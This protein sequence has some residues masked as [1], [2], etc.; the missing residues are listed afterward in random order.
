MQPKSSKSTGLTFTGNETSEN[1]DG[2]TLSGSMS[3]AA[4][5]PVRTFPTPDEGQDL[6]E[7][8]QDCFSRPFAWFANYDPDA[9]CWK[10]WQRCLLGDWIEFSGRWP[11]SG[12][13]RN[14]I[15]YRLPVLVPRISGTGCS[16]WPTPNTMDSLP[17]REN[18]RTI[19]NERDGRKNRVALSNLREAVVD[20]QY[21][22]MWPTPDAHMG[23]GGR[24]TRPSSVTDTGKCLKTGKKRQITL[25][26]AV[27]R[28]WW[29]T[30]NKWDGQR[31]GESKETKDA[32]GSGGVNLVQAAGGSLNPTWVEWLMGFPLGWTDCEDSETP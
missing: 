32:R 5:F 13:M 2:A 7:N 23:T 28:S 30:P 15:A 29:P 27:A 17:A 1:A 14:G 22:Q 10:T 3:S 24:V 25:N 21:Q 12:L 20:E 9:L 18:I 26:D 6:T 19:N 31:G 16:S 8:D 11:R 4:A